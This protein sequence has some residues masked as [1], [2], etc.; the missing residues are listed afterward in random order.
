MLQNSIIDNLQKKRAS[1]LAQVIIAQHENKMLEINFSLKI[2]QQA[3]F[4]VCRRAIIIYQRKTMLIHAKAYI[5][6][7]SSVAR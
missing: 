4:A 3:I 2:H 5:Y 7:S 1:L 6:I